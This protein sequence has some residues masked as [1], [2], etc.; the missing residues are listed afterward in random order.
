MENFYTTA[1]R[2]AITY[3]VE[4]RSIRKQNMHKIEYC[5]DENVEMDVW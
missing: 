1:V 3:G 5:G 4:C 2:P